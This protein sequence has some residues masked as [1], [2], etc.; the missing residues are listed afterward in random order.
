MCVAC[1]AGPPAGRPVP[2]ARRAQAAAELR[3]HAFYEDLQ[4]RQA[5]PFPARFLP[6]FRRV[7]DLHPLASRARATALLRERCCPPRPPSS[8]A[9][10]V[11]AAREHARRHLRSNPPP[12]SAQ[13]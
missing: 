6:T 11:A 2:D 8:L 1:V 4:E 9:D 3:A 10:R 13:A 5:L 12:P 7:L